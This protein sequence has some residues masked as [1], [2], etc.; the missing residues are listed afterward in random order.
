MAININTQQ[1][2][3]L[4]LRPSSLMSPMPQALSQ[5]KK[6]DMFLDM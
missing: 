2:T 4:P 6:S 1:P 3:P 5:P